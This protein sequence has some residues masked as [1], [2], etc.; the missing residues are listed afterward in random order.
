[1]EMQLQ[2][3]PSLQ[4]P[5]T[6]HALLLT[7]SCFQMCN[8]ELL[9]KSRV[10][11]TRSAALEAS[12][13]QLLLTL[14]HPVGLLRVCPALQVVLSPAHTSHNIMSPTLPCVSRAR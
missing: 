1:M 10:D 4:S 11:E 2:T 5:A 14:L 7:D 6:A 12:S 8:V 9:Q 3:D 13:H